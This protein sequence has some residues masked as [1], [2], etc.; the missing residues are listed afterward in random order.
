MSIDLDSY[1]R[2]I[3]YT[4]DRAPTLDTLR[5]ICRLHLQ[6]IPYENLNPLMKWPVPLDAQSLEQKL[7]RDG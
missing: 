4:G 5:H 3:G 2:R 7:I 1:F 6:T